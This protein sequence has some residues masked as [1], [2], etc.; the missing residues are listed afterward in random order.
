[1]KEVVKFYFD[2]AVK[3]NELYNIKNQAIEAIVNQLK[4][5]IEP[6]DFRVGR[7]YP[8]SLN[9]RYEGNGRVLLLIKT[10]A[11]FDKSAYDVEVWLSYELAAIWYANE[12]IR[13]KVF[14]LNVP[15]GFIYNKEKSGKQWS[16][17]GTFK[18]EFSKEFVEIEQLPKNIANHLQ[19]DVKPFL[20]QILMIIATA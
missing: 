13:N 1:M 19:L 15:E 10:G 5:A 3:I 2:N 20:D 16:L 6:T 7:R 9:V 4:K 8:E 12:T 14:G 17:V 11:L 18:K